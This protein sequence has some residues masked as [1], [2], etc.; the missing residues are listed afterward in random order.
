M[1]MPGRRDLEERNEGFT[2]ILGSG[3]ETARCRDRA[4]VRM[5]HVGGVA[6]RTRDRKR[7]QPRPVRPELS[8]RAA[9]F[10]AAPVRRRPR[11]L[12]WRDRL[13]PPRR[14]RSN[15]TRYLHPGPEQNAAQPD[16]AAGSSAERTFEVTFS[17]RRGVRTRAPSGGSC[18]TIDCGRPWCGTASVSTNGKV[19]NS[20]PPK[21]GSSLDSRS[22][23]RPGIGAPMR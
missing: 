16:P 14:L 4:P 2:G 18:K 22:Y 7:G 23:Q 15:A 10:G 3:A 5:Q 12:V 6:E 8:A 11:D 13:W 1:D 19:S 20:D 17:H 21:F 9:P